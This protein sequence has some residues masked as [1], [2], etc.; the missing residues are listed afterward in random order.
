MTVTIDDPDNPNDVP[1]TI[2]SEGLIPMDSSE[3]NCPSVLI[4]LISLVHFLHSISFVLMIN[5]QLLL[6]HLGG[7]GKHP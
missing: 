3:F 5:S 2:L 6:P 7:G 4:K 1:E